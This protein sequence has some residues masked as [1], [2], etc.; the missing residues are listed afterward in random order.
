[1]SWYK[2]WWEGDWQKI[3]VDHIKE[4]KCL[5][6]KDNNEHIMKDVDIEDFFCE[7]ATAPPVGDGSGA[8]ARAWAGGLIGVCLLF[9][10]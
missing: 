6:P 2:R 3:D 10:Y 4:I 7:P 5:D 8:A 1:M 9:F